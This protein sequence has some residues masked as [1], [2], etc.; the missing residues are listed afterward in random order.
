MTKDE[1][2]NS[3]YGSN[4]KSSFVFNYGGIKIKVMIINILDT[5][6]SLLNFSL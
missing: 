3:E 5:D 6:L 4:K 1:H 2:C